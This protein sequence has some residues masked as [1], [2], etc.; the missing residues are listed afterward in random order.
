MLSLGL[1]YSKTYSRDVYSPTKCYDFGTDTDIRFAYWTLSGATLGDE[2]LDPWHDTHWTMAMWLKP[3]SESTI[4]PIYTHTD[5]AD[6]GLQIYLDASLNLVVKINDVV[7][8]SSLALTAGVWNHIYIRKNPT[9]NGFLK[10]K[11]NKQGSAYDDTDYINNTD[12]LE[13][14][15]VASNIRHIGYNANLSGNNKLYSGK[16]FDWVVWRN[17]IDDAEKA[18]NNGVWVDYRTLRGGSDIRAGDERPY[19]WYSFGNNPANATA[20][21]VKSFMAQDGDGTDLNLYHIISDVSN[22]VYSE[23]IPD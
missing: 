16:M 6:D 9:G 20:D 2:D 17:T 11:I 5:A 7:N 14:P 18:F 22:A 13:A 8:T 10:A 12:I 21:E 3:T 19:F 23:D 1:S 4:S 15:E